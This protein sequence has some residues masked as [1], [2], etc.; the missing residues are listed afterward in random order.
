[1]RHSADT[2]AV[3]VPCG[4]CDECCR[5]DAVYLHPECGDVVDGYDTAIYSGRRILAHKR[6]GDC[7]YLRRKHGCQ[8]HERRPCS[9]R[10]L[11]CKNLLDVPPD[12]RVRIGFSRRQIKAARRRVRRGAV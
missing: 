5:G 8:I 9:C 10:Q 11:D 12:Q 1:M 6:N 2:P 3:E 4:S 7:V